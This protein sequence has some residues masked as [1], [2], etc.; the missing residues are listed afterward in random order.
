[1]LARR[2][3]ER[4]AADV[5]GALLEGLR[6]LDLGIWRPVPYAT[7]LLAEMGAEVLKI[8]PPGG[9]PMRVFP[10]LFEVLN[11][12][13]A[14]T[15]ADLK[16]D[17]GRAEVLE[18]AAGADAVLEG[19][20]P[21]VADRLGVGYRAVR[22]VQ[23]AIV[24]CSISGYGEDG[25]LAEVPGHD[26]NYQ[27]YAGTLAPRGGRPVPATVPIGDLGAGMTAAMA[28][29]A[30][31]FRARATGEGER[32]DVAIADVLA[33]WTGAVGELTPHGT[34]QAMNG[35]P[36]YG[37]YAAADGRLISLGVLA[38][39]HF[40]ASLCA[41]LELDDLVGIPLADRVR[42]KA[43]LD[44]VVRSAVSKLSSGEV[45]ERMER[46]DVPVAPVLDRSGMLGHPHFR[47]RGTVR[48][49]PRP[50][51]EGEVQMGHPARYQHHP[52]RVLEPPP[53]LDERRKLTWAPR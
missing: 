11:A 33:T 24:Y 8:E 19:F 17:D 22:A 44:E 34:D 26:I 12:G 7:Q 38:E 4:T 35:L 18:L 50:G 32:I 53:P 20:R 3:P 47:W 29:V 39:T 30:A 40:W 23:P 46:H 21:G 43:E 36:A 41:A 52:A 31:C 13:K 48:S 51:H 42:R 25:P 49:D 37:I 15:V 10:Q 2:S 9:D 6:V 1:M 45:M 16:T 27:A 5:A 14:S 28:T